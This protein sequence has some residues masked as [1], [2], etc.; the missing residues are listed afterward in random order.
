MATGTQAFN[1]EDIT[2]DQYT[3]GEPDGPSG[4]LTQ[5]HRSKGAGPPGSENRSL[6]P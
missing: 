2:V 6:L 1:F 3:H 5:N 4:L